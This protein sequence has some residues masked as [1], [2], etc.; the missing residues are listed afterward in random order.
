MDQIVVRLKSIYKMNNQSIKKTFLGIGTI[1]VV[2]GLSL[3]FSCKSN[4]DVSENV[5]LTTP[6]LSLEQNGLNRLS[7]ANVEEATFSLTVK[8]HGGSLDSEFEAKLSVWSEEEINAYNEKEGTSYA[9]LPEAYYS[10]TSPEVVLASGVKEVNVDVKVKAAQIISEIQKG[11]HYLIPLRLNSDGVE[12][13]KGKRDILLQLVIDYA[14]VEIVTPDIVEKVNVNEVSTVATVKA[15]L[16]YKVDGKEMASGW[17]FTCDLKVPDNAAELLEA[18]NKQYSTNYELLPEGSYSLGQIKYA[19]GDQDAEAKITIRRKAIEVKYYLLPLILTNPS[20]NQVTC[21]EDV[22]YMVVGQFYTNPIISDR[23]VADPTVIRAQDGRFYLYATQNSNDWMPVYSS[24]DLVH[25]AYEKNA[26]QKAT[27]PA[28]NTDNA[29]WAPEM[30]YFNGKYVLYYSYA[31]MNGTAQSHTCVVTADS[32]LGTYTSTYP[33]GAFLDSKQLLSNEE[34]GAN[35]IDQ[36]YY[37]EDGHKYLFYGSF[38][39]IYVV[40]LADDGLA[41]KR[42]TDGSLVFKQQV[43]GNAF[44]GTNIYKKGNYYYLFASIGNCCASQNSSYEVVVG[45]STSLLGPYV[46]KAGKRMLDNSWE[47]VL[48]GGDRTKWVGPGHNSVIIKDDAGTEWMIYHS[49]YYKE[50]GNSSTFG[51]RF[52]ML[53]RLQWTNDG[54]PYIKNHLPS[55]S[56]LIPVFYD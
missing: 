21:K 11:T 18:Y 47:P 53:D 7:V 23:S 46:D 50:K 31:K 43:C 32:P 20:I 14:N 26:F 48:D 2:L 12:L 39:G 49:F 10:L 52:G 28:W 40:E 33:N 3:L 44:E 37:E 9:I 13:R 1:C 35:C 54:W 15:I 29:F 55:E 30:R 56:D 51:G 45:R 42:N 6:Y 19:V 34:F 41:V 22:H 25:S 36:F 17:D 27:K 5:G 38:T 4:D 16:D 24:D 8:R